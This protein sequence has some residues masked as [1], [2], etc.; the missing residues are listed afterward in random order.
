VAEETIA[1]LTD[2]ASTRQVYISL[3]YGESDFRRS[4]WVN[5]D[6]LQL[7]RVFANLLTNSINH[8]L[9][10]CKIEV[11]LESQSDYQIVKVLDTGLGITAEELPHL[12]ERFYQGHSDRQAK[13]SGLGLYLTRQ[14]IEA[15]R[16][17]IWAENRS[18]RGALFGFRLPACSFPPLCLCNMS[19]APL[20]ILLVEDDE[21]FRLGLHMRLQQETGLEIVAEAED[22]ETA[23]EL[24]SRHPLDIVLLDVGLPGIGE[25]RLVAKSSRNIQNCQY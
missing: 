11:V 21:L 7:Q 2:L 19:P 10:G 9:R 3:G 1:T 25:L 5:G 23:V 24:A 4:M 18:P 22:G 6:A 20:R 16:G 8:S 14:I 13:G 12:F 15:H 17:T